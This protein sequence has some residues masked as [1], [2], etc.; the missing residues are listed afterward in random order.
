M[1]PNFL[2]KYFLNFLIFQPIQLSALEKQIEKQLHTLDKQSRKTNRHWQG[3]K[4]RHKCGRNVKEEKQVHFERSRHM[5]VCVCSCCS[6]CSSRYVCVQ[7]Q[8]MII[9]MLQLEKSWQ[10]NWR[11]S[12]DNHLQTLILHPLP[13]KTHF[14]RCPDTNLPICNGGPPY[15]SF[16]PGSFIHHS[17]YVPYN[18]DCHLLR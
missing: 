17:S 6:S 4:C 11:K 1:Q 14:N 15:I 5:Y 18:M 7:L 3:Q 2:L 16:F 13:K 12:C 9:Y 10:L 8:K